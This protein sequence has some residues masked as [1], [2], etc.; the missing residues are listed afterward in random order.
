MN[1]ILSPDVEKRIGELVER[2]AY[3]S[4][5]ALVQEALGSFLDVESEED[6]DAL[7]R[8]LAASEAEVDRGEFEEYDSERIQELAKDVH[9]RGR[10]R[11]AELRKT[12]PKGER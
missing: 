8:R 7:R 11:L 6:L 2:G 4:A 3:P 12:R 5:E 10:K 9:A 1:I